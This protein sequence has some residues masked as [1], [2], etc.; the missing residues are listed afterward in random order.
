MDNDIN[1]QDM[2]HQ[3]IAFCLILLPVTDG[4]KTVY[5]K[6]DDYCRDGTYCCGM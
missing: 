3:Y 2:P 6:R 1:Q 5:A 4:G